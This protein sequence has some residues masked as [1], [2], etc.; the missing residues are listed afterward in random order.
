MT[1]ISVFIESKTGEVLGEVF[2]F[3][4]RISIGSGNEC[5][6]CLKNINLAELENEIYFLNGE[7]WL[8][9]G[10]DGAPVTF[11][12]KQHRS[13]KISQ[14]SQ[15]QFRDVVL[16]VILD[17]IPEFESEATKI[18][19]ETMLE[20]SDKTR[21]VSRSEPTLEVVISAPE[22]S[23]LESTRVVSDLEQTKIVSPQEVTR[24]LTVM[25]S[26]AL[27]QDES[28]LT[29]TK[30]PTSKTQT[31]YK[32]QVNEKNTSNKFLDFVDSLDFSRVKVTVQ[33]LLNQFQIK[34]RIFPILGVIFIAIAGLMIATRENTASSTE[35]LQNT[36]KKT[37]KLPAS[38]KAVPSA[39]GA[40]ATEVPT[41]QTKDGY[42]SEMSR[43]FE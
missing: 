8:Q 30:I 11:M 1:K 38:V 2:S 3:K 39:S 42:L 31:S 22:L 43:L 33:E 21:I 14:S 17:S 19:N 35:V 9:V 13:I 25:E 6:I 18:V 28:T 27:V 12:G 26:A 36:Q 40:V 37:D 24:V 34:E 23:D 5:S 7:C 15:F 4:D 10:K 32:V 16:K 41:S 29:N 20:N